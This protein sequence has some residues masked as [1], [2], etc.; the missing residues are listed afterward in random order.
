MT[1]KAPTPP[2]SELNTSFAEVA[3][4]IQHARQRAYQGVNTVLVDLYRHVG[5]YISHKLETAAWGEGVVPQLARYL[6]QRHPERKGFTRR[7]LFR[8]K[9]FYDTYRH[10]VLC[11]HW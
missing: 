6:Q 1:K 5:A 9:Q 7:N 11:H 10:E 8:M 4:M 3:E 2:A